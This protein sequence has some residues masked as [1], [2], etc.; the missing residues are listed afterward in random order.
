M[1]LW[2]SPQPP[3]RIGSVHVWDPR[4]DSPTRGYGQLHLSLLSCC[5]HVTSLG[6]CHSR[7]GVQEVEVVRP[8]RLI[9]TG[10]FKVFL[11]EKQL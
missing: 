9:L 11:T 10:S 4:P 2:M 3:V 7:S 5:W 8:A 1:K 6:V